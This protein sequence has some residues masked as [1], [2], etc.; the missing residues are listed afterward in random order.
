MP[1]LRAKERARLTEKRA[2]NNAANLVFASQHLSRYLADFVEAFERNH[3]FVRG[4]L[5]N[6][7]SGCVNNRLARL[8]MF[9]AQQFDDFSATR[10]NVTQDSGDVCSCHKLID[11]RLRKTIRVSWEGA[12]QNDSCH[13]PMTCGGVF[14]V[15]AERTLSITASRIFNR[16]QAGQGTNVAEAQ[17]SQI[18]QTEL[19]R[20]ADV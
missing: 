15:R 4:D 2:C 10:G 1:V 8:D 13:F 11:E 3:F 20:F 7:I 12:L 18:R 19:P 16:R 9:I 5:K 6:R 14:A 17:A